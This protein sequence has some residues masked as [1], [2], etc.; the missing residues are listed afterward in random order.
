M[1]TKSTKRGSQRLKWQAR[2]LYGLH[3]VLC[4]L[5]Y[6]C[7]L[8]IFVRLLIVGAGVFLT[9]SP[10]LKLPFLLLDCFVKSHYEAFPLVLLYLVSFCLVDIFQ[11]PALSWRGNRVCV[12]LG[13]R[14]GWG[15]WEAV[16]EI[17]YMSEKSI[18]SF[19]KCQLYFPFS[20]ISLLIKCQ[21]ENNDFYEIKCVYLRLC[22]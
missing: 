10:A 1:T 16:V 2:G 12:N 18:F 20:N 9:L 21:K 22:V 13:K 3:Q 5:C 6:G 14:G 7:Q 15:Q 17:Y 11:R 4:M 8:D 19:K